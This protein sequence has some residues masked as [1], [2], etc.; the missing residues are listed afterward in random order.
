MLAFKK[1]YINSYNKYHG[2]TNNVNNE[3]ANPVN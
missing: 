3:F 1:K 2:I